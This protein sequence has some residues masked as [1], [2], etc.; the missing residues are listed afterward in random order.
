MQRAKI[1]LTSLSL[2][3]QAK[4]HL[5][6]T[7]QAKIHLPQCIALPERIHLVTVWEKGRFIRESDCWD[8]LLFL[9]L[10]CLP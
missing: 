6:R 4:M 10:W 9:L 5:A 7:Q 8:E 1:H 2:N 3:E